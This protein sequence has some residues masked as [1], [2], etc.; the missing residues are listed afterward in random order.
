MYVNCY[1]FL[2]FTAVPHIP[3]CS[4]H[5]DM[6]C[7]IYAFGKYNNINNYNNNNNNNN[8]NNMNYYDMAYCS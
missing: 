2:M 1:P 5:D 7:S 4:V 8:N 3:S 6:N